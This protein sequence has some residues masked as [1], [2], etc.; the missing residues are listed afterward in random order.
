[1][2]KAAK[3]KAA[4]AS[5][6]DDLLGTLM[7]TV[8]VAAGGIAAVKRAVGDRR[9]ERPTGA[10]PTRA[11]F[12]PAIVPPPAQSTPA[13]PRAKAKGGIKGKLE[14]LGQRFRP[15][16]RALAVQERYGDLHGNNLA[17]AVTFQAFVSLFPLLLVIVAIIGFVDA[18][19][20]VSV[21]GRIIGELGLSGDAAT[22]VRDAVEAARTSRKVAGPIGLAGLLWSGLGLVDALQYAYNQVWQVEARGIKDKAVGVLWLVGAAVLF[23]GAAA[24]TTVLQWLPGF[25]A[26]L[27][28]VIALAVNFGLWLWTGKVL[29]NTKLSWRSMVPGAILGAIGLEV[30]KALGAFYVPRA[31]SSS[32][33]LYGSLGVVFALLAWLFFFGRLIVYSAVLNV[34]THE[35]KAG[36]L[37]AVIQ[38]PRQPGA[39]PGDTVN[40]SGRL[41]EAAS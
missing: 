21:A 20:G 2:A 32:S 40:R 24:V 34:V 23:V 1:M 3:G 22:A 5:R 18:Q 26:P 36:T 11:R 41:E 33:Q 9:N 39:S 35:A 14:R 10:R 29:P 15:L 4:P 38:V 8:A 28:I 12:V 19:G 13:K 25:L 7:A 31:V 17:A 6:A 30:L 27:G 37:P 16:G